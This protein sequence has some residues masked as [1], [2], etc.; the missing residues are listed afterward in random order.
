KELIALARSRPGQLNY[1]TGTT[2][3]ATH[4]AA[5]KFKSMAGINMVRIPYKNAGPGIT[6]LIGGEVQMMFAT[7]GSVMPHIKS[8]R[9]RA[10]GVTSPKPSALLPDM[11]TVAA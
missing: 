2:G 3:S 5:E 4:I 10:L 1:G 9:L 11:P 8:G 7:A 6:A